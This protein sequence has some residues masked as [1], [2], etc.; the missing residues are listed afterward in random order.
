MGGQNK[1]KSNPAEVDPEDV[2]EEEPKE[3]SR[4]K[5]KQLTKRKKNTSSDTS[6]NSDISRNTISSKE[7][8][9]DVDQTIWLQNMIAKETEPNR[10]TNSKPP[11]KEARQL[12]PF[13]C[14]ECSAKY[15]TQ[16]N[17]IKHLRDKH[18]LVS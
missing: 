10:P 7:D 16:H 3:K 5:R 1:R 15:K 18:G 14:S 9:V 17:Y 4:K 13:K 11:R 2:A 12:Y 8:S 6:E